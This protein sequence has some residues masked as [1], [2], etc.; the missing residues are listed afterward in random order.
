MKEK[1]GKH[2]YHPPKDHETAV[3]SAQLAGVRVVRNPV[4]RAACECMQRRCAESRGW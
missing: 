1:E 2:S 3:E 4:E